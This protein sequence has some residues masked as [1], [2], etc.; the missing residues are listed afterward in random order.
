M[1]QRDAAAKQSGRRRCCT[2]QLAWCRCRGPIPDAMIKNKV[3]APHASA[4]PAVR[5]KS[6]AS[7]RLQPNARSAIT[8]R[9]C[10]TCERIV[11]AR[12]RQP[13]STHGRAHWAVPAPQFRTD[14]SHTPLRAMKR[15]RA[16]PAGQTRVSQ[17]F[18]PQRTSDP[19]A[20]ASP[21]S[22][23]TPLTA[24]V[25]GRAAPRAAARSLPAAAPPSP[26]APPQVRA[27]TENSAPAAETAPSAGFRERF[28]HSV[29]L[30]ASA[31]ES[32]TRLGLDVP[33]GAQLTQ[34]EQQ[35]VEIKVCSAVHAVAHGE[36]GTS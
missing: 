19:G 22:R 26:A 29:A 35:V 16:T 1:G 13:Q 30:N 33:A 3:H 21:A 34:L 6:A 7:H 9:P 18:S 10:A 2:P 24:R 11:C 36:R 15:G 4:C 23:S 27:V 28:L 25:A 32:Q 14:I 12:S 17:Y 8:L 20:A 5:L 31:E